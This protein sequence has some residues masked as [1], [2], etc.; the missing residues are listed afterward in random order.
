MDVG[1]G[2]GTFLL[3]ARSRGWKVAGI[4]PA[5]NAAADAKS[6]G[7]PVFCGFVEEYPGEPGVSY[8]AITAFEVLEHV[9]DPVR[10]LRAMQQLLRPKG[11]LVLSVP[12]LD[13]PF[14]LKQQIPT[15]MPPIHI[16][17]FNRSSLTVALERAGY[18]E[19]RF[20]TLPVPTSSV[21]NVCGRTGYILRL[22]LLACLSALGKADG[23]TLVAAATLPD[24]P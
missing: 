6:F 16:N 22:P 1:C 7:L 10:M 8:D 23:T 2:A 24:K 12:N 17:F 3:V 14:C 9:P 20:R 13:D 18:G 19:I 11:Q 5:E 15:A 21:R 4:E